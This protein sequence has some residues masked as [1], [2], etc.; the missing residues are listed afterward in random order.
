MDEDYVKKL[1]VARLKTMP[2][3]IGFSIGSFG[4]FK[5]DEL[6]D[7]VM[8]GTPIGKEFIGIELKM[9]IDTPKLVGR[10]SGQATSHY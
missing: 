8:K 10:L 2:P 4:D 3:N 5:R 9:L 7:N 1:V 6:I